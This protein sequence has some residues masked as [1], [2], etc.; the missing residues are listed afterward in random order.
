MGAAWDS[1]VSS[2]VSSVIQVKAPDLLLL[3]R[4]PKRE[5]THL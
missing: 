2:Q 5:I 1:A 4:K 3:G